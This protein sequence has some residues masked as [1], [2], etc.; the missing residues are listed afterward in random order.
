ML[1]GWQYV[2]LQI[3]G[4]G[5][6]IQFGCLLSI[7]HFP[8]H[9]CRKPVYGAEEIPFFSFLYVVFCFICYRQKNRFFLSPR[10]RVELQEQSLPVCISCT[11]ISVLGSLVVYCLLYW[12]HWPRVRLLLQTGG[13]HTGESGII[14]EFY[15][16]YNT[17]ILYRKWVLPVF[18]IF[19]KS[20]NVQCILISKFRHVHQMVILC[21][22][23]YVFSVKMYNV[24]QQLSS[25]HAYIS[26]AHSSS[27][28]DIS[29]GWSLYCHSNL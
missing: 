23:I 17:V 12:T 16:D 14:V 5:A 1:N 20:C 26:I 8:A 13:S 25:M 24:F 28:Q 29:R 15:N 2:H 4:W 10:K 19:I 21:Q 9:K 7:Q 18:Y 27:I 22:I 11:F 3:D 6:Q